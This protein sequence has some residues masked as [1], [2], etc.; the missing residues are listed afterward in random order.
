MKKKEKG[1]NV[2]KEARGGGKALVLDINWVGE[3]KGEKPI[4]PGKS[5]LESFCQ[6]QL[7]CFITSLFSR[8]YVSYGFK[9]HMTAAN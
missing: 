7:R 5:G 4:E 9:G 3:G 2:S 1:S 8:H 6:Q